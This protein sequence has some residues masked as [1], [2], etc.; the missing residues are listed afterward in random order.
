MT[1]ELRHLRDYYSSIYTQIIYL[2]FTYYIIHIH[3]HTYVYVYLDEDTYI[4]KFPIL[5]ELNCHVTH[6]MT[7]F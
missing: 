4:C 6:A 1:R 5:Y 2:Y 7:L 3:T